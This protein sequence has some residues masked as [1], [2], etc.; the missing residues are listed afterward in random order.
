LVKPAGNGVPG[1]TIG[2]GAESQQKSPLDRMRRIGIRIPHVGG[3]AA[4]EIAI[5]TYR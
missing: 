3:R 5:L 2:L 4:I 1:G